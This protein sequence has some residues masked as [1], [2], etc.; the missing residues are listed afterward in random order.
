MGT[1]IQ[2]TILQAIRD[3]AEECGRSLGLI[4]EIISWLVQM[5]LPE[6][7]RN[8]LDLLVVPEQVFSIL[9]RWKS[10]A[11]DSMKSEHGSDQYPSEMLK[12]E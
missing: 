8:T 5:A 6:P 10:P 12:N 1:E 7:G 4:T 2:H 3:L 9:T 11:R